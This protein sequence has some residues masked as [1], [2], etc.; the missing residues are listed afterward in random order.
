VTSGIA[1]YAV[2][3]AGVLDALLHYQPEVV[4]TH[5]ETR[6][7]PAAS[8]PEGALLQLELSPAPPGSV[9]MGLGMRF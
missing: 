4:T 9:G 8:P 6:S 3:V 5:V 1:F 2:Y 7:G